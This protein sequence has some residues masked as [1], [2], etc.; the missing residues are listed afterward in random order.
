MKQIIDANELVTAQAFNDINDRVVAVSSATIDHETR[1][2]A[3]ENDV[4]DLSSVAS[5]ITINGQT[6]TVSNGGVNIGNY[7]S[8]NTQYIDSISQNTTA[9]A[10][11]TT[12][13]IANATGTSSY[14]VVEPIIIDC[15]TY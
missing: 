10:V 5:A 12:F 2:T 15:G 1:I 14:D 13:H 8:G 9:S 11:T 3:L 7:L 6:Y 4:V